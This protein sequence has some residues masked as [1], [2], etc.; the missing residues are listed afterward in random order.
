MNL[1]PQQYIIVRLSA[2][3]AHHDM[4]AE[5][6]TKELEQQIEKLAERL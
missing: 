1:I 6:I 2:L 5:G 4:K 3:T